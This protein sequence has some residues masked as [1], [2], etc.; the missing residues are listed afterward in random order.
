MEYANSEEA[1]VAQAVSDLDR[2]SAGDTEGYAQSAAADITYFHNVPALARMDG[3]EAFRGF[4][5]ALKGK[6]P[7]HNY[8]IVDPKVQVYGDVGVY[9][10]HYH[11][12]LPDGEI[13]ARGRGTVVF[14]RTDGGWKMVHV[15]W[16]V[17]EDA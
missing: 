2:W 6:I 11:A 8:E 4:L 9:T 16:S 5:S 17:L 1:I 15:H 10:L 13:L 12:F 14:R 3:I 7:A